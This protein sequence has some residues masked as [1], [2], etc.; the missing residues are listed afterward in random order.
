MWMARA[1]GGA[2]LFVFYL[3]DRD[4]PAEMW[5]RTCFEVLSFSGDFFFVILG[6]RPENP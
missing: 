5:C 2:Q 3:R 6:L 1:T 4:A